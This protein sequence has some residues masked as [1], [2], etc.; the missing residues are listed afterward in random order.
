MSEL[1]KRGVPSAGYMDSIHPP[2]AR[3]CD[4]NHNGMRRGTRRSMDASME[5]LKEKV[6]RKLI[7]L[8]FRDIVRVPILGVF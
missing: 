3:S 2:M 4:G 1:R 5:G 7:L 8:F 6:R